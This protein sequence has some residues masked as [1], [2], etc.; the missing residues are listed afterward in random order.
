M[1]ERATSVLREG[2]A[3]FRF[4]LCRQV[5][6]DEMSIHVSELQLI[7]DLAVKIKS[8]EFGGV[9]MTVLNYAPPGKPR[10]RGRSV[11]RCPD[12]ASAA[13]RA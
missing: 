9:A 6:G 10:R 3:R 12:G 2:V 11:A 1:R 7:V 4:L 13:S 8:A 5:S